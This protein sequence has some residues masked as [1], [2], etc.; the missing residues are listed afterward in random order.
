MLGRP[1]GVS[2][3]HIT[4]PLPEEVTPAMDAELGAEESKLIPGTCAHIQ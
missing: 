2:E 4:V 1:F 3:T